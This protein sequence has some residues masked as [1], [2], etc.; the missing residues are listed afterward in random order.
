MNR[1]IVS[2]IINCAFLGTIVP[3]ASCNQS[4]QT[5]WPETEIIP[6]QLLSETSLSPPFDLESMVK[7]IHYYR[8]SDSVLVGRIADIKHA[9]GNFYLYDRSHQAILVVDESGKV[10]CNLSRQGRSGQ[11][12]IS[13]Y[14]FD[15]DPC[16]GDIH[17]FDQSGRK[18]VVYSRDGLFL[19]SISLEPEYATFR[20][21]AVTEYGS[22]LLYKEDYMGPD[23]PRGLIELN[24]EGL[25]LRQ[26]ID[27]PPDFKF[28]I[29]KMPPRAFSRLSDNT[30][31]IL[32]GESEN[33]IYHLSASGDVLSSPY[34]YAFDVSLS[35]KLRETQVLSTED[36]EDRTYYNKYRFAETDRW[37]LMEP[38]YQKKTR[39]IIWDKSE[40]RSYSIMQESDI[41][42]SLGLRFFEFCRSF[43]NSL[44][45]VLEDEN[46][47]IYQKAINAVGSEGNPIIVVF[48][49]TQ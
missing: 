21:F 46:H 23:Y 27:L 25:F 18:I 17:I 15:V 30:L 28:W 29:L 45:M 41:R 34:Q 42:S 32:G 10:L 3:L 24:E 44:V 6:V 39:W 38:V 5:V 14:T 7:Q 49:L 37:L 13:I 16:N 12:Y 4:V 35:R 40:R 26:L 1:I 31:S 19:R 9:L 20:D 22:Y 36:R 2:F 8:I 43:D 11:E 47:P 33:R 48:E